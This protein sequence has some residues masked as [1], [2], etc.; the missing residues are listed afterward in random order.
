MISPSYAI[1]V[2]VTA[3]VLGWGLTAFAE[4][5]RGSTPSQRKFL[6]FHC[7]VA[8]GPKL[9]ACKPLDAEQVD[10]RIVEYSRSA[11]ER[12]PSCVLSKSEI[13]ADFTWK[14][15]YYDDPAHLDHPIQ[16]HIITNPDYDVRPTPEELERLYPHQARGIG[17]PGR[18]VIK[19][20]V[21]V[22]GHVKNCEVVEESPKD[23]GFGSA[24][25]AALKLFRFK[26]QL[27]DC[28]PTDGGTI[29]MSL[30]FPV[31]G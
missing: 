29:Q 20:G 23:Y 11:V 12:L 22:D 28:V 24:G 19:C 21:R 17:V 3:F 1:S 5:I 27:R 15:P 18:A 13:G 10:A 6:T 2:V 9:T 4:E 7:V 31:P 16:N 30:D 14:V 25:L 8:E 26:P